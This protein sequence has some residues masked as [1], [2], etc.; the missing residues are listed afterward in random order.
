MIKDRKKAILGYIYYTTIITRSRKLGFDYNLSKEDYINMTQEPCYYCNAIG[1]NTL[2]DRMN[3]SGK[4]VSSII[5]R[6]NGIDRINNN[7]GYIYGNIITC[8]KFCNL[9]R[10]SMTQKEFKDWIIKVHKNYCV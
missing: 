8:C 1:T 7:K 3:R 2:P 6:Y 9:A 5:V 4:R 10:G